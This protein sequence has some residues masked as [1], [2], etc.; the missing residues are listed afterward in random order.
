MKSLY[1]ESRDNW[2]FVLTRRFNKKM[3]E[4]GVALPPNL[5]LKTNAFYSWRKF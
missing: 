2:R 5:V 4:I 1:W 3:E